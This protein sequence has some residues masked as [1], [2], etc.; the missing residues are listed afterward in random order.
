MPDTRGRG[1]VLITGVG[2][3]RGIGAAIATG[4]AADGFDLLLNHWAPYDDRLGLER[5][6]DDTNEVA[7]EC[8]ALGVRT[9]VV[10]A[11]LGDPEVPEFLVAATAAVG[12]VRGAV[13]SHCESVDSHTLDTTI[14]SWD[15]H[16]AV[17]ARATWLLIRAL[18]AH[19]PTAPTTEA[20]LR[21]V[22]LTSDH[23]AFNLPY[24][25]SKGA[26]DR[27]VLAAA[28][29]LGGRGLRANVLN[30][31]P[32]DTGWMTPELARELTALTPVGRLGVPSD[33]AH[34]VRFLFSDAGDWITGQ[35][36]H[37]NGGFHAA[38]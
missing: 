11:D 19:L 16:F 18:A 29:E 10:S 31:G 23:T 27:T 17:N 6:A 7:A 9:E 21:V 37:S 13:L 25:A 22:A 2:R 30:P 3:R 12:P 26:L 32:I 36:L 14:E 28:I 35:L 20:V 1:A 24:G 4:L 34:L 38:G 8:R 33:I 15:R 5:G